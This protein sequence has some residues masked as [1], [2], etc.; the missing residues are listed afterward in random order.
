MAELERSD[1]STQPAG[2]GPGA[3][4][5]V[6]IWAR[7]LVVSLVIVVAVV[8][9]FQ[10]LSAYAPR[11]W[12]QRVGRV[13]DGRMSAGIAWGLFYGSVFSFFAVMIAWQA[14]R[15][16]VAWP[17]KPVVV[18]VGLLVALPN[19]LTLWVVLGTTASAH[20]G[21][22]IFDVEAPGFRWASL[23]GATLGVVA[24]LVLAGILASSRRRKTE[25]SNLKSTIADQ[26]AEADQRKF[27]PREDGPNA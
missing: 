15:P 20:A 25:L 18:L 23:I 10:V 27:E 14:R 9:F 6:E 12:A 8:I 4:S 24:A 11:A 19:W 26:A 16:K 5:S 7:R 3:R 1:T 2:K 17:F 13:V 21:E 22:R